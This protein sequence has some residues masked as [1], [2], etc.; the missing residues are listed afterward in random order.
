ML[1]KDSVQADGDVAFAKDHGVALIIKNITLVLGL[2]SEEV[3]RESLR[4]YLQDLRTASNVLPWPI[5][6]KNHGL[7][8]GDRDP[9]ILDVYVPLDAA[10]VEKDKLASEHA[11]RRHMEELR[12]KNRTSAQKMLDDWKRLALLGDPGSGKTTLSNY[13]TYI[14][15]SACLGDMEH[16]LPR[17]Q[18]D[19]P[20]SHG[21]LL[22]VR[23]DL[24]D[25]AKFEAWRPQSPIPEKGEARLLL[26]FLAY[27]VK[28]R[29]ELEG[30]G[31]F[32]STML[33]DSERKNA[34]LLLLDGLDEV[35][36]NRRRLVVRSIDNF[37]SKYDW[38]RYVVT[39]RVYAYG[40]NCQLDKFQVATLLPFNEE[41]I[42]RF[43]GSCYD[44]WHNTGRFPN[45][46]KAGECAR[47][48]H[49]DIFRP[50]LPPDDPQRRNMLELAERPLLMAVMA[51]L[52]A[53]RGTLA[54]S[55]RIELYQDAVKLLLSRW[56]E[57]RFGNDGF[58]TMAEA[59]PGLTV[60]DVEAGFYGVAFDIH[61]DGVDEISKGKLIDKMTKYCKRLHEDTKKAGDFVAYI[62]DRAGLLVRHKDDAYKFPHLSFQEFLAACHLVE[63]VKDYPSAAV[64]LL[65]SQPGG[66]LGN[67][68]RMVFIFAAGY[69]AATDRL[70]QAIASVAALYA[71][72]AECR[73]LDVNKTGSMEGSATIAGEALLEIS[74][75]KVESTAPGRRILRE[76]RN[77][78]VAVIANDAGSLDAK[79]RVA[80]GNVLGRLGDPRFDENNFFLPKDENLGF[81]EIP[82]G[83]F[84]MGSADTDKNAD[85]DEKPAHR[86]KLS[87]YWIGKYPV[88]VAQFRAFIDAKHGGKWD[89]KWWEYN[90]VDNH[91]VRYVSWHEADEYCQWLTGKL[92]EKAKARKLSDCW[93]VRLLTQKNS[94]EEYIWRIVLPIEAQWEFAARGSGERPRKWPWPPDKDN[95]EIRINAERANYDETGIGGTSPVGC[96]PLGDT[97]EKVADMAGNVWEWCWDWYS[98]EYYAECKAR[99]IV[100]DP[101][102]PDRGVDRAYRGGG[103]F[104]SGGFCRPA[105]RFVWWRPVERFGRNG[106]RLAFSQVFSQAR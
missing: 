54:Y 84:T 55:T 21:L 12:Q 17:L 46:G 43:I 40:Q 26:D 97:P 18:K 74:R 3:L 37:A 45:K 6:D 51:S 69:A 47:N 52:H 62:K 28:C 41:Q 23:I 103:W 66:R 42:E 48:L 38:H 72:Y 22:P 88:T 92:R 61:R 49:D 32:L 77:W 44:A 7:T 8:G 87:P 31:K 29:E 73:D 16:G 93:F 76:T 89:K 81:V 30:F 85:D 67:H 14:M 70:G 60:D 83:E 75:E 27:T 65:C 5:I 9:D 33:T 63:G 104:D 80:A 100:P 91:P 57:E 20:W 50:D 58:K 10:G 86:V 36:E 68:W 98:K 53:H 106:F 95:K 105:F 11:L 13:M 35:P 96:F 2:A 90:T 102:G 79:D 82:G 56:E 19:G 99:G 4:L 94:K 59:V 78:L 39:C 24:K 64:S 15:A 34:C 25:F 71:E 1:N 101:V